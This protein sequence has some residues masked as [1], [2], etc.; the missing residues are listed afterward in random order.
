MG[1]RVICQESQ[2]APCD[3]A[4]LRSE[5]TNGFPRSCRQLG[6]SNPPLPDRDQLLARF[7]LLSATGCALSIIEECER[8][9]MVGVDGEQL[10]ARQRRC[11]LVRDDCVVLAHAYVKQNDLVSARDALEQACEYGAQPLPSCLELGAG[12]LRAT[13]REP[14]AG[15]GRALL[16]W[17]CPQMR[18]K[19]GPKMY[20]RVTEC[21]LATK[22]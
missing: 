13:Y 19:L 18:S 12:Y 21:D 7:D 17:A 3:L 22:Q 16:D 20:E 15:R 9:S 11:E 1:R 8:A 4:V 6:I 2:E 10:K 14:A 5:C